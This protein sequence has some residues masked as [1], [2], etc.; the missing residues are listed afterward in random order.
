VSRNNHCW[1]YP[2]D[3]SKKQFHVHEVQG[4]VEIAE[5]EEDP[6]DHRFATVSGQALPLGVNDHFHEIKF[7]TDF[8]KTIFM[9]LKA[10]PSGQSRLV[11]DMFIF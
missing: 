5:P 6:H 2:C 4:S 1:S 8:I 10:E 3:E 7:R 9:N 11:T